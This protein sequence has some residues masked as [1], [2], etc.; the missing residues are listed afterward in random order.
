MQESE[1]R[2]VVLRTGGL[3]QAA[4]ECQVFPFMQIRFAKTSQTN[5]DA[6]QSETPASKEKGNKLGPQASATQR[7][8]LRPYS[9]ASPQPQPTSYCTKRLLRNERAF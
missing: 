6:K 2:C 4:Q 1:I 9:K 8:D 5:P 3:V 7:Q